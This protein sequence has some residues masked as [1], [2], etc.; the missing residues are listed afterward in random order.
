MGKG[1]RRTKTKKPPLP[2]LA[3]VK[4][5]KQA[6][7]PGGQ[8]VADPE[9]MRVALSAR[10]RHY[11]GKD[12][13]D[14]RRAMKGVHM[15]N[16]LGW[17]LECEESSKDA[18]RDL[19]ATFE[20]W[21]AAE[22]NYR[23]RYLGQSET[24]KG[25]AIG[26]VPDRM[27]TDKSHSVDLRTS[28]ERDRDAVNTWMRWKG[29]LGHLSALHCSALHQARLGQGDLWKDSV[30]TRAGLLALVALRALHDVVQAKR[31]SERDRQ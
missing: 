10:A 21:C 2:A 9:P 1:D 5:K 17:V 31:V 15:G 18:R 27:E 28:D 20:V 30:P 16:Q 25:A 8:F 11:T 26:Y 6:R 29:Y 4:R 23:R 13:E 22:A 19:W 3:P 14:T 24:A 12:S 7:G